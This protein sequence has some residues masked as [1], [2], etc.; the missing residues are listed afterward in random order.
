MKHTSTAADQKLAVIV[1]A[2]PA[3]LTAAYELLTRTEIKP[4]VLEKSDYMGGISRTVNYKGNRIDI[5]GHRFFSKS[6][7]VMEWWLRMLPLQT[8]E[9]G[10]SGHQIP[11]HG[12]T[13]RLLRSRPGS[14]RRGSRDVAES[15]QIPHLLPAPLL[16]LPDLAQ[17]GHTPQARTVADLQDRREL[18]VER[19]VSPQS[20]RT[21]WSSSSSTASA[22]NCTARFS[23]P[24]PRRSG[25]CR[26]TRSAPSGAR[27]ASRACHLVYAPSTPCEK[28][29][30][31]GS[32]DIGQKDTRDVAHRTVPVPQ[33]WPWANVGRGRTPA[34]EKGGEIRT[35]YSG[36]AGNHGSLEG[37]SA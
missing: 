7:R 12:A 35:G 32:S 11:P 28:V 25:A 23:S 24:T 9:N 22:E 8:L 18:H 16:R 34:S 29:F 20:R 31:R 6:D 2:G 19:A 4:I 30:K 33:V 26:A 3:G 37:P 17:Q 15:P 5:G 21:R 1:G 27:S 13:P 10:P 36:R 14:G